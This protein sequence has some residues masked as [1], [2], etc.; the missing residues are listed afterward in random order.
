MLRRLV[1]ILVGSAMSIGTGLLVDHFAQRAALAVEHWVKLYPSR[2][3][4]APQVVTIAAWAVG[5]FVFL[6][7]AV[8]PALE[9]SRIRRARQRAE[10]HRAAFGSG[11]RGRAGADICMLPARSRRSYLLASG[12]SWRVHSKQTYRGGV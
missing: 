1:A 8:P 7:L 4:L 12:T 11:P 9:L 5:A 6:C 2:P 10:R 3:V